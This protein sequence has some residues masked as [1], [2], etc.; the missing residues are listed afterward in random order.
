MYVCN[1]PLRPLVQ[2]RGGAEGLINKVLFPSTCLAYTTNI[3]TIYN[4]QTMGGAAPPRPGLWVGALIS[5]RRSENRTC[6]GLSFS[7][8]KSAWW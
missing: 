7:C 8:R 4:T 5:G 3:H 6:L 1:I 2:Q